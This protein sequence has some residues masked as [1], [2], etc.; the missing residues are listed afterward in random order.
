[1][2]KL[3]VLCAIFL[4]SYAFAQPII[5]PARLVEEDGSPDARP[6]THIYENGMLTDNN[7][8]SFTI[9]ASGSSGVVASFNLYLLLDASNDPITGNLQIGDG[10]TDI[11]G[12]NTAP[13][14]DQ[15]ITAD[16]A[17]G[18]ANSN[19]FFLDG[20]M[21]IAGGLLNS[22]IN[23]KGYALNMDVSGA[24][25]IN[26][27][28]DYTH[29]IRGLWSDVSSAVTISANNGTYTEYLQAIRGL[30]TYSGTPDAST[31]VSG[32]GVRGLANGNMGTTGTTA[33][34]GG[35]FEAADT[36]DV[37]YGGFFGATGATTNWSIWSDQGNMAIDDDDGRYYSGNT[38]DGHWGHDGDSM[39][40]VA[41]AVTPTDDMELT[42]EEVIIKGSLDLITSGGV[43]TATSVSA[44]NVTGTNVW[45]EGLRVA[46]TEIWVEEGNTIQNTVDGI[47]D[48]SATK[49]YMVRVPPGIYAENIVLE[50]YISLKG[51]GITSTTIAT[52]GTVIKAANQ[53]SISDMAVDA[54]GTGLAI[55]SSSTNDTWYVRDCYLKGTFDL[56]KTTHDGNTIY[57]FDCVGDVI[58]DGIVNYNSTSKM[59]IYNT[60]LDI[61]GANTLMLGVFRTDGTSKFGEMYIYNCQIKGSANP[62]DVG[63]RTMVY[64]GGLTRIY[65]VN[66]EVDTDATGNFRGIRAAKATSDIE[67]YGSKVSM[68]AAAGTPLDLVQSAGTLNVYGTNYSTTSGTI[69]GFG[70]QSNGFITTTISATTVTCDTVTANTVSGNTISGTNVYVAGYFLPTG[71]PADNEIIKYDV[72]TG[73]LGWEADAQAAG[74][75]NDIYIEEGDVAKVD[76][77]AAD[78][79]FNFTGGDFDIGVAGQQGNISLANEIVFDGLYAINISGVAVSANTVTA[80]TVNARFITGNSVSGTDVTGV[81]VYVSNYIF[82]TGDPAND[83]II[84]YDSGTGTLSWEADA[85]G[86]G[87]GG[88]NF[89]YWTMNGKVIHPITATTITATTVSG[90]T[91]SGN[92]VNADT[93]TLIQG[94]ITD[95]GGA[96][97]FGDENI[98]TTGTLAAGTTTITGII[99]CDGLTMDANEEITLGAQKLDH[100]G[101][102]FVFDDSVKAGGTGQ[103]TVSSG[104]VVN[105]SSGGGANDDFRVETT[106]EANAF[107]VD[108]SGDDIE[109]AV[110]TKIVSDT[111]KLYRGATSEVADWFNGSEWVYDMTGATA[112]DDYEF[113]FS[114]A[115]GAGLF[116]WIDSGS[117]LQAWVDSD[118][119]AL[120]NGSVT[121]SSGIITQ[122]AETDIADPPTNANLDAVFGTPA[123]LGGGF[124][125]II[126]DNDA[127]TDVWICWTSDAEWYYLQGTKAL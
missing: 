98:S 38:Q 3:I 83:Q 11:H 9:S 40:L 100:D 113:Y 74:G 93:M 45:A 4:C 104:L 18:A 35:R 125:G 111:K 88:N 73:T 110:N 106:G 119:A 50:D 7:D 42:A 49:P 121:A 41:N 67:V 84:K 114:D 63:S 36:A 109:I 116:K 48:A 120:F 22:N 94:S 19:N 32:Y 39:N 99:T 31:W 92:T 80:D 105:D 47:A 72:G 55:V 10:N 118:G 89:N 65:N 117:T 6:L 79:T 66:I 81:N 2:K 60:C 27:L 56:V 16:F 25:T 23:D 97:S 14:A 58:Y 24:V 12:I 61:S 64:G 13:V 91:V 71:F 44:T 108:A 33:H 37:N 112:G 29:D 69:G 17:G 20:T 54:S 53:V 26:D 115:T 70:V 15:M 59:Y 77:S 123:A 78:L 5:P 68:T 96:I 8:G 124:I 34:Y 122:Y 90:N 103:S 101:T 127:D 86:G 76:S 107:V 30:S 87:G 1:M 21:G 57:V 95:S 46:T 102:D 85:T 52:T 62:G 43:I 126:D 28:G 51:A 82:P 75:G